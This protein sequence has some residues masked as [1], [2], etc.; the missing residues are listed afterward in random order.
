MGIPLGPLI[1]NIFIRFQKKQSFD[2]VPKLYCYI[3]YVNDTFSSFTLHSKVNRFISTFEHF[4]IVGDS[5]NIAFLR[6][7]S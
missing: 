3:C 7:F 4:M 1:A 6:H 2:K 5:K